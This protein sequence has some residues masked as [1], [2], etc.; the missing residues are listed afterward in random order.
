MTTK[1]SYQATQIASKT[2]VQIP[3]FFQRVA[4]PASGSDASEEM[5]SRSEAGQNRF[6]SILTWVNDEQIGWQKP[7]PT[8]QR[9]RQSLET[10]HRMHTTFAKRRNW[11]VSQHLVC[12]LDAFVSLGISP[13]TAIYTDDARSLPPSSLVPE[14][15]ACKRHGNVKTDIHVHVHVNSE[16]HVPAR[17]EGYGELCVHVCQILIKLC[18]LVVIGIGIKIGITFSSCYM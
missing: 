13:S 11:Q 17:H 2:A 16:M 12:L 14:A 5:P 4:H 10:D 6:D 9:L 8:R 18:G 15:H 3:L 1:R 7:S